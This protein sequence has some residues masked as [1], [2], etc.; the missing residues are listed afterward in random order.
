MEKQCLVLFVILAIVL[1]AWLPR[2]RE[3][4]T[5]S[6]TD[7]LTRVGDLE[8]EVSGLS[9]RTKNVEDALSKQNAQIQKSQ[10]DV[11]SAGTQLTM[12]R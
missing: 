9:G 11:Q 6:G 12:V 5:P 4:Y 10:A 3:R 2:S 8:T 1:L 7:I